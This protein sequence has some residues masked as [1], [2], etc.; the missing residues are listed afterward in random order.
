MISN[1]AR[2]GSNLRPYAKAIDVIDE[3]GA[4][5]QLAWAASTEGKAAN[6][7]A[8]AA[9]TVAALPVVEVKQIAEVVAQWT[10]VPVQQLSDSEAAGLMNIEGAL[11][12]RVIGRAGHSSTFQPNL[13]TFCV[14]MC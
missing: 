14:W 3:A 8:K 9:G 1:F 4:M 2:N 12:E 10:G 13:N 5:V 6:E 7:A 11:A